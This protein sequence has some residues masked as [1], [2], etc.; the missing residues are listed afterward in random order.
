MKLSGIG[1]VF[2]REPVAT[3]IRYLRSAVEIFGIDRCVFGSNCPPDTLFY[4]FSDLMG[5]YF[6]ALSGLS[7]GEQAKIFLENALKIYRL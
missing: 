4:P 6:E 2:Q 1:S 5:I 3:A 7:G